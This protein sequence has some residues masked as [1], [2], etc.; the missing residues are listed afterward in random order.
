MKLSDILWLI[1]EVPADKRE[2]YL[3]HMGGNIGDIKAYHVTTAV[4]A[5]QIKAKGFEAR[6]SRQS[7]DRPAAVYF[8]LDRDEIDDDNKR[9]L[10]D[11]PDDVVIIEVTIPRDEFLTKSQ[12][13]GLYNAS[14]GTSRRPIQFFDNVPTDW[15]TG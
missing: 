14:F 8:F 2:G 13:D 9:I 4:N 10:L 1:S 12:W 5:D 15:I 11:N 3:N 7:Y 6:S